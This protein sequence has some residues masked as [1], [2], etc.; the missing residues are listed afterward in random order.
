MK[1]LSIPI[2]LALLVGP[3]ALAATKAKAK[4]K[5]AP[6]AAVVEP[7]PSADSLI[8]QSR[9]AA[10][11]GENEL[12][13]RLAQSAIVAAPAEPD[14]YIALGDVY[15]GAG[16]GDYA[17]PYYQEALSIDPQQTA[18]LKALAALDKNPNPVTA[19]SGP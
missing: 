9:D 17:R 13:E 11:R 3:P 1:I 4:A 18:A 8:A 14:T 7:A 5:P 12:A 15:R 16:R 6:V 2:V 10:A 19:Q